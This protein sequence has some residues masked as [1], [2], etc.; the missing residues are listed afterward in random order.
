MS[1]LPL[2]LISQ[3]GGAGGAAAFELISTAYGTGSSGTITFSSIPATY[4]HLQIRAVI[5]GTDA[6]VDY[7][8][9]FIR[10]NSDSGAN[11]TYHYLNGN[12]SS[13]SSAAGTSQTGAYFGLMAGANNSTIASPAIIDVLDYA[14]TNKNKTVRALRGILNGSQTAVELRSNLW[15]STAAINSLSVIG[16]ANFGTLTRIS[17][18]GIRGQ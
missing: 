8:I 17:L 9:P 12:G 5:K 2:G 11:Y 15:L 13:V 3:G 16:T 4:T 18:Y 10:F 6:G 1:L 7:S 14:N